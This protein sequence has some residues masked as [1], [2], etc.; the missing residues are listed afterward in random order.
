MGES[1]RL[2]DILHLDLHFIGVGVAAGREDEER[3]IRIGLERGGQEIRD[4]FLAYGLG[5]RLAGSAMAAHGGV[6]SEILEV[7]VED[8]PGAHY[9][10]SIRGMMSSAISIIVVTLYLVPVAVSCGDHTGKDSLLV[11][12]LLIHIVSNER[13]NAGF[14]FAE[15]EKHIDH[16]LV[17]ANAEHLPVAGVAM[18]EIL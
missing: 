17:A 4:F 13:H 5:P 7:V 8:V 15:L 6:P 9:F 3:E 2:G 14:D 16:G 18:L 10:I 1:V 11:I 12:S